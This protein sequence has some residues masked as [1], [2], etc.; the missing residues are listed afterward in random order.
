MD[1]LAR[2]TTA[3]LHFGDFLM[4]WGMVIGSLGFL[5][6][7]IVL[8][9]MERMGWSRL[10]WNLPLFFVALAVLFGCVIGLIL[11]P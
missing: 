7:W 9:V 10:V 2:L 11:S 8:V 6:A 4:P 5:L 1:L 3:E